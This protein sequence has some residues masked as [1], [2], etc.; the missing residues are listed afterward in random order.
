VVAERL[1]SNP[2]V[3]LRRAFPDTDAGSGSRAIVGPRAGLPPIEL[4]RVG[5]ALSAERK[6]LLKLG[7]EALDTLLAEGPAAALTAEAQLGIEAIVS[8]ARPALMM[9][10]ESSATRRRLG[11]TFSGRTDNASRP[12]PQAWAGSA[13]AGCRSC[14]TREPDSWSPRTW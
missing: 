8:V 6:R 5:A 14:L 9:R 3:V 10:T 12:P 13:C 4:D 7:A 11:T 2:A 1:G